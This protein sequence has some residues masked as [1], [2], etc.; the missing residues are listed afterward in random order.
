MRLRP[1]VVAPRRGA[2]VV[3]LAICLPFM[4]FLLLVAIDY[5]RIFYYTQIVAN[6]ARNGGIY[7]AD[8][9]MAASSHYASLDEAAKADAGPTIGPQ[10]TVS[11]S[12]G[13][14]TLGAY[15][16]VTV[17]Y[18]FNTITKYPWLPSSVTVTRTAQARP[19]P[20]VPN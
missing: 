4:M 18:T 11:S 10:L 12:T 19:A 6:C 2:A 16:E 14:D 15:I 5:C 8:P 9:S 1:R 3:E 20:A 13:S 7:S 17:S